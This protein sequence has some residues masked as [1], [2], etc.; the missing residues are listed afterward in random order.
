MMHTECTQR[1]F[2][3]LVTG[4]T[5]SSLPMQGSASV[6]LGAR[7]ARQSQRTREGDRVPRRA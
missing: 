6:A 7:H 4:L 3:P 5:R 1:E 2:T